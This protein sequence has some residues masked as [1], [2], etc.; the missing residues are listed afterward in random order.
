MKIQKLNVLSDFVI[1]QKLDE[2]S[3]S[4]CK[5]AYHKDTKQNVALKIFNEQIMRKPHM[6]C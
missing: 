6:I 1:T 2:G 4:V 3:C 5:K